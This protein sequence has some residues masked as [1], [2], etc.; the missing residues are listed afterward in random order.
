MCYIHNHKII[1]VL[2]SIVYLFC[3]IIAPG[4]AKGKTKTT[5]CI[6]PDEEV[7]V[8]LVLGAEKETMTN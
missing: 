6:A 4:A 2:G 5:A 8:H 7:A 1:E 3:N